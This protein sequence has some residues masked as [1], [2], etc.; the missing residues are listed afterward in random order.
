M[1]IVVKVSCSL[2]VVLALCVVSVLSV[3]SPKNPVLQLPCEE[4]DE[5][6]GVLSEQ[7]NCAGGIATG[8]VVKDGR[9]IFWKNRHYSGENE[10]PKVEH[11]ASYWFWMNT[12]TSW[13]MNERGLAVGNFMQYGTLDNWGYVSDATYDQCYGIQSYLLGHCSTV[14][15]AAHFAAIH[16]GGTSSLGIVS[17]E[18][19]V[20]AVVYSGTNSAGQHVCNITWVNNSFMALSNA[21]ECDGEHDGKWYDAQGELT[22]S[23][24]EHGFITWEDVIQEGARDV[25]NKEQ[26]S[27]AFTSCCVTKSNSLSSLVAV[28]GDPRWNGA[29]NIAWTC[30]GRQPLVGIYLPLG[31]SYLTY[32]NESDVPAVFIVGGGEEDYIDAKVLYATNGAGQGS[33]TYYAE[34]VREIQNYTFQIEDYSFAM[35]D[36]LW[37]SL[38]VGMSQATVESM[39][40][41]FVDTLVP[42][43][44]DAYANEEYIQGN[45]PPVVGDIPSQVVPVGQEFSLVNLDVYV[46]DEEDS[47]SDIS[48]SVTGNSDLVV[49]FDDHLV[50]IQAPS[51]V[52]TGE[53]TLVFTAEDTGGLTDADEAMFS[54]QGVNLPPVISSE[55]PEDDLT[56]VSVDLA[57]MS[58]MIRDPEGEQFNWSI[59]SHP[60]VGSSSGSGALNGTKSC[61]LSGLS[62]STTY[63]WWVNASDGNSWT[64]RTFTFTTQDLYLLSITSIGDGIVQ[65]DPDEATYANGT[66]VILKAVPDTGWS[67]DH[68]SGALTGSQNPTSIVMTGNTTILAV[69]LQNEYMLTIEIIGNGSGTVLVD[70][71]GPYTYGEMVNVTA[72]AAENSTF[73]EWQGILAGDK[74]PEQVGMTQNTTVIAVFI[75]GTIPNISPNVPT[76]VA[77]IGN[78][79]A[80]DADLVWVGGDLDNDTVRYDVYFGMNETP[81]LIGPN[82]SLTFFDPGTLTS[83]TTYYWMI[84]AWDIHGA[85]TEGPVWV[86]TT[87]SSQPQSDPR[88][89]PEEPEN[90]PPVADAMGPYEG[91]VG[92]AILFNGSASHDPDGTIVAYRWDFDS[93]GIFDT[94]W[95][96][97]PI[98]SYLYASEGNYTVTLEVKDDDNTTSNCT[99]LCSV[100]LPTPPPTEPGSD[101][102]SDGSS[103]TNTS[104]NEGEDGS[105]SDV[106]PSEKTTPGFELVFAI[107]SLLVGVVIRRIR[108]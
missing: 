107:I 40:R 90:L 78:H 16:M 72:V 28:T 14:A 2:V 89:N 57:S 60:Y 8:S 70:K 15:A 66:E 29:A 53:E 69:F 11:G 27:G 105:A 6:Y 42:E 80:V 58:V 17:S 13:G 73:T 82:V 75:Y 96:D 56:G 68:W 18:P 94:E 19:G 87:I 46:V 65:L 34:K 30:L 61:V 55:M 62:P 71:E 37:S 54:V 88:A 26:G 91:N 51:P 74:N 63:L 5:L 33:N 45:T 85:R 35:Y 44:I 104:E 36:S 100:R 84:I 67:F 41:D 38:D 22:E 102:S 99:V 95:S 50:T 106:P 12:G 23:F 59:T 10:K 103:N 47:V 20:G 52:W 76:L 97:S 4:C 83:G 43:M 98:R 31:A 79:V 3:D 32:T 24:A 48:W 7:L 9:S 21:Y 92:C 81:K 1:K 39:L 77:P 93:D 49:T 64:R 108:R 86:F 25:Q 101:D